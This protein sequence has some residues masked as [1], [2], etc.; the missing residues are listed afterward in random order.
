MPLERRS[1]VARHL[2]NLKQ[3]AHR[4]RVVHPIAQQREDLI[5]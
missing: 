2:E 3:L 4:G 1:F 5:T